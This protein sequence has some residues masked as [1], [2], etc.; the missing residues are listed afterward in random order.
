M[1]LYTP[2]FAALFLANL[3]MVS[4]FSA[5]F[6]FPLYITEFGGN[7][8]DIGIIM[9]AF[10][11]ASALSRPWVAEMIDRI[12]RKRSYTIGTIIMTAMPL[13]HLLLMGPIHDNYVILLG[14]RIIHGIGLAI[15]F[16]AVFYLYY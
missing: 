3:T 13:F 2:A 7:D 4:S 9:G 5:F 10:A 16:T 12:G 8:R 14:V 11:M 1:K 15:C 6:L